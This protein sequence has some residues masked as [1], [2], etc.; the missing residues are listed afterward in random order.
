MTNNGNVDR[1]DNIGIADTQSPP[2]VAS[3]LGPIDLPQ[4][5]LAPGAAENCTATYTVS[6]ADMDAGSIG[7]TAEA[8]GTAPGR[9]DHDVGWLGGDR[10]GDPGRRHHDHQVGQCRLG[11]APGPATSP[12]R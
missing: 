6:Q 3:N 8:T 12:S 2:S 9:L 10:R 7:D 4:P 11:L 5:S 1:V